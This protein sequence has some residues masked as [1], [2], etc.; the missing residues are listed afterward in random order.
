MPVTQSPIQNT[1]RLHHTSRKVRKAAYKKH[2]LSIY[3]RR[4]WERHFANWNNR[5]WAVQAHQHARNGPYSRW[6][7]QDWIVH[8]RRWDSQS[9]ASWASSHYR[10]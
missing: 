6:R 3:T 4:D 8:F 1:P 9:W 10:S 5:D 2:P 7:V